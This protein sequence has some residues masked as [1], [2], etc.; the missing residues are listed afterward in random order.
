MCSRSEHVTRRFDARATAKAKASDGL[1]L[2]GANGRESGAAN[3]GVKVGLVAAQLMTSVARGEIVEWLPDPS[4]PRGLH[5][6]C[7]AYSLR[8]Y[9]MS[10]YIA[11][12]VETQYGPHHALLVMPNQTRHRNGITG[13]TMAKAI[14]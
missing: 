10:A 8:R 5:Y 12:N 11:T 6:I 1:D 4:P 14:S 3:P 9:R 7:M 13:R 2:H